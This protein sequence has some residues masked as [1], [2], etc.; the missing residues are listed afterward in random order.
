MEEYEMT[1]E[2]WAITI[3]PVVVWLEHND[4]PFQPTVEALIDLGE[5][6]AINRKKYWESIRA[7]FGTVDNSPIK[8][9]KRTNIDSEVMGVIESLEGPYRL[10]CQTAFTDP[11]FGSL[12][13]PRGRY[14][15]YD[16]NEQYSADEWDSTRGMLISAYK[17]HIS[18]EP[19]Q[20]KPTFDGTLNKQGLP[21]VMPGIKANADSEDNE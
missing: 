14:S 19:D 4:T 18:D 10:V 20:T 2:K 9:G 21:T 12:T 16:D 6:D 8:R 13:L 15:L 11:L 7:L 17:N 5:N 3:T 1:N